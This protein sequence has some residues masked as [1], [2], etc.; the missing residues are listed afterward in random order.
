MLVGI[1]S[2]INE[3]MGGGKGTTTKNHMVRE[4]DETQSGRCPG[5]LGACGR[6][7]SQPGLPCVSRMGPGLARWHSLD[8]CE[9]LSQS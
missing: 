3:L 2:K 9:A 6:I 7:P 4:G 8:S 5:H 1:N